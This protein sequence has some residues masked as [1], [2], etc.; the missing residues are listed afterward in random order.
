MRTLRTLTL[1]LLALF[2]MA[3]HADGI[4][5]LTRFYKNVDSLSAHFQQ[6]QKAAD[7]AV[8][9]KSSGLFL[10]SRPGHFRWEYKEP[11]QQIMVSDG[12]LFQFYDVG[13]A[14]VT[15][16]PVTN[17]LRATPALLLTGGIALEKAFDVHAA[18]NH[19]GLTWLRL[20][21]RSQ[22]SDFKE[23]RLG[24]SDGLPHAMELEDRLGQ[25]TYIRFTGIK[26]NPDIDPSRF[27]IDI[28]DN[29]TVVDTRKQGQ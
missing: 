29:V 8:L 21:P 20:V 22:G 24:L 9:R 15:R 19:D 11:Y 13:L 26:V 18:G 23:I 28:P 14:Q 6:T 17:T 1:A 5:A 2:A 3:A 4:N 25:T 10:L 7:G 27:D 12:Q 16:R